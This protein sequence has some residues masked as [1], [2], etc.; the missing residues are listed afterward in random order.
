MVV[1]AAV[2]LVL[3]TGIWLVVRAKS[4]P[5]PPTDEFPAKPANAKSMVAVPATPAK[6]AT[7][8]PAVNPVSDPAQAALQAAG[9]EALK[10]AQAAFDS[11]DYKSAAT[12]TA[13]ALQKIPGDA[14]AV[15][16]QAEALAQLKNLDAGHDALN[17]AQTA[18]NNHDYKNAVAWANAALAKIPNDPAAAKLR[19]SAQQY[20]TDAANLDRKYQ[21]AIA[22][23]QDARKQNNFSLAETK[24]KEALAVRPNDPMAI[25]IIKQMQIAMDLADARRY[26]TQ[27][28]YDTVAQICQ[29]YPAV[30]DFKQ[31]AASSRAE[32]AALADAKKLLNAGDYTLIA[33][34]QNQAY[35]HKP[36]FT[37]LLNQAAGE[38]KLL[39]GLETLKNAGDWKNVT[40]SLASPAY[41]AVKS[42]AA[43]SALGQWAQA[44]SDQSAKQQL[45]QQATVRYEQMLVWFNVKNPKDPAI[46]TAEAKKEKPVNGALLDQQRQQ[47]LATIVWLENEFGKMG[48]LTQND[49]AKN[50]KELK[51]TVAHHE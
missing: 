34:L 48:L 51:D 15:K 13:A 20:L 16:L 40:G 22:A 28:D 33:R 10:N 9:H 18:F 21:V 31:L 8:T 45:L 29:P 27:G 46:T 1:V 7:P 36:P 38:Q 50:L 42:K 44:Q 37:E 32:Q 3:G 2:I 6:P 39:A 19:D 4:R 47:Y 43:F 35:G 12:L 14:A 23:A 30:D 24:A 49:R 11:H 26:F 17:Q 41:A 5:A 25:Q